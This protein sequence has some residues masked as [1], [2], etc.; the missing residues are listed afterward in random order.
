MRLEAGTPFT[1]TP[2]VTIKVV[3]VPDNTEIASQTIYADAPEFAGGDY[4]YKEVY[5]SLNYSRNSSGA[6]ANSQTSETANNLFTRVVYQQDTVR[7]DYQVYWHGQ[8]TCYVD[9]II[10]ENNTSYY[11]FSNS[12]DNNI[13]NEIDKFKASAG[14]GKF[15]ISTEAAFEWA[16][17]IGYVESKVKQNVNSSGYPSKTGVFLNSGRS[18]FAWGQNS[19]YVKRILE[20]AKC[21]QNMDDLYPVFSTTPL[22]NASNYTNDFQYNIQ[23]YLV[24]ALSAQITYSNLYGIPFWFWPQVFSVVS[25]DVNLREPTV[26]E[27]RQMVNLG[28]AYGAKGIYYFLYSSIPSTGCNGLV[29]ANRTPRRMIYGGTSYAGNKWETVK[30]I[31]RHL[32]EIGPT[33]LKLTWQKAFSIHQVQPT[34]TFI[35]NVNTNVP[36]ETQYVELSVFK[37]FSTTPN[38]D[39]FMLVNRRTKNDENRDITANFNN[40]S[41]WEITDISSGKIW[42]IAPNGSFTDN[43]APAEGKIYRIGQAV[44]SGNKQILFT[45]TVQSGATLTVDAGATLLFRD[46]Y[47][48]DGSIISTDMNVYGKLLVN[49]TAEEPVTIKAQNGGSW[50]SINF[51]G[52]GTEHSRIEYANIQS[53][54]QI[55]VSNV[56]NYGVTI[57]H[58]TLENMLNG[59]Y[60]CNAWGWIMDNKIINP[61]QHG[62]LVSNGSE[63]ACYCNEI[64]KSYKSDFGIYYGGGSGDYLLR[65]KISGFYCGLGIGWGSSPVLGHPTANNGQNNHITDCG[66]GLY[67][68]MYSYPVI[69]F[70]LGSD[71]W[72][73]T[74]GNNVYNN[75]NWAASVSNSPLFE[76]SANSVYWGT[77]DPVILPSKFSLYNVYA[78][79]YSNP[80][81]SC[82][83]PHGLGKSA[84]VVGQSA[85][86]QPASLQQNLSDVQNKDV[87]HTGVKLRL[88]GKY[89]EAKEY[90]K[91][92]LTKDPNNT[93]AYIELYKT[94]NDTTKDDIVKYFASLSDDAPPMAKFLLSNLYLRGGKIKSAKQV[95]NTL[96]KQY[97][98]SEISVHA[99]L[100]NFYIALY[101][102]KDKGQAENILNEISIPTGRNEVSTKIEYSLA[103]QALAIHKGIK[104]NRDKL[105]PRETPKEV[106]ENVPLKFELS[107]NYPNPFNPSTVISYQLSTLSRVNLKVY[108][109]LGREVATMV[110]EMKEA[111]NHTTT[112]DG[113]KLASGMY[114]ARFIAQPADGSKAFVQVKKLLLTK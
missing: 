44:W 23:K 93:A 90:F 101:N 46:D 28:I 45:T 20:W 98:N 63:V 73:M 35:T 39:Y 113:S 99:K 13:K 111:G 84:S 56:S 67:I 64:T 18:L 1:H 12:Y 110:D 103:Q 24:N 69:G 81:P 41:S 17:P 29:N 5:P 85:Q 108:D 9:Y 27:I 42:I 91:S 38:T 96:I 43:L 112:F 57:S 52:P 47:D 34:E 21:D 104:F 55:F 100:N 22:P 82:T 53:G 106:T 79:D 16:L 65:N 75:S 60:Y 59:I 94:Q 49:G 109:I 62:I 78:F 102:E 40:T 95:N 71:E 19:T 15:L 10:V 80:L 89:A 2:V 86:E 11:L 30:D 58:C 50:G 3:R 74:N 25:N 26:N 70:P 7:Y 77:T 72:G 36:G 6:S 83:W 88:Q 76:I 37:D 68:Y 107:Q 87:L 97:P 114:F 61:A 92:V 105:L 54:T 8:V 51:D 33:L 32:A 48:P 31:N 66:I 14:L 4:S